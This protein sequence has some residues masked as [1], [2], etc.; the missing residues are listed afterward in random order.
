MCGGFGGG[1]P[2]VVAHR[3][4]QPVQPPGLLLALSALMACHGL[5]PV[6]PNP[7]KPHLRMRLWTRWALMFWDLGK[8]E[9][10]VSRI[11]GCGFGVWGD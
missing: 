3:G 11:R 6:A 2:G 10:R 1:V 4:K 9:I 7:Q 5:L 8:T